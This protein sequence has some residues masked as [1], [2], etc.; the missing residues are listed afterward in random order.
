MV[1]GMG[2]FAADAAD[3]VMWLY[4]RDTLAEVHRVESLSSLVNN[5]SPEGRR[6]AR[7]AGDV[8][9]IGDL[10]TG[11]IEQVWETG[12]PV[13]GLV[14]H[15]DSPQIVTWGQR[16]TLQWRNTGAGAA[17]G[18]PF[19]HQSKVVGAAFDAR[20]R[21]LVSTPWDNETVIWDVAPQQPFL[22][23]SMAGNH[24][25]LSPEGRFLLMQGWTDD[26]RQVFELIE[27]KVCRRLEPPPRH[28]EGRG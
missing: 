23:L 7:Y 13:E 4:D 2:W 14:W 20:G 18:E 6:F 25:Q 28:H 22:R 10:R 24:L 12:Q 9:T 26:V 3:D 1:P 17:E 5:F 11:G 27:A 19:G 15:P 8:V 21:W 16:R